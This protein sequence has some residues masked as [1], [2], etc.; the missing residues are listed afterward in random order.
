MEGTAPGTKALAS[1]QKL[2]FSPLFPSENCLVFLSL[3]P[4]VSTPHSSSSKYAHHSSPPQHSPPKGKP[5]NL[6]PWFSLLFLYL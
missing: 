2:D 1:G 4:S 5:K 6:S 3:E